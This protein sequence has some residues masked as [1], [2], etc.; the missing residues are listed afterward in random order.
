MRLILVHSWL[1]RF[2]FLL[3]G[4]GNLCRDAIQ[5]KVGWAFK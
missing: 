1:G 5:A 2:W 3:F 4:G